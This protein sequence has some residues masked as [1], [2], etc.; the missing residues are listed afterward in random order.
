MQEHQENVVPPYS[1]V[2]YEIRRKLG[3]TMTDYIMLDMVFHLSY[4]RWCTKSARM[5]AYDLGVTERGVFKMKERLLRIGYL[6]KNSKGFLKVTEQFTEVAMNK[7]HTLPEQGMNKVQGGMN[8]VHGRYEQSS[9]KSY[10]RTTKRIEK[11]EAVDNSESSGYEWVDVG[12][13][14]VRRRKTERP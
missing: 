1:T 9:Y 2:V 8:K 11:A 10:N 3:I 12:G 5:M 13:N 6:K 4:D 7:V 14:L